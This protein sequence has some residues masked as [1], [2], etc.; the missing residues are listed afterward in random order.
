MS[1]SSSGRGGVPPGFRFHPTD[2]ELLHFYLKKKVSLQKFDMEVIREVDLNKIEPWELQERCKIGSTPQNEWYFFSHKD[3]K[4]PTGSRTNRATSAGF[5]KAT[6]RDKCIRNNFNK[7]GM[8]KT[9]VFYRGRAPHGQ[10]TDWIMHEYRLEDNPRNHDPDPQSMS[11]NE[12][13]WVVCRVF[14]KKKLLKDGVSTTGNTCTEAPINMSTSL[15]SCNLQSRSLFSN[16][17]LMM[18]DM[19]QYNVQQQQQEEVELGSEPNYSLAVPVSATSPLSQYPQIEFPY[20]ISSDNKQSMMSTNTQYKDHNCENVIH[21]SAA[22][23]S[24]GYQV[25]GIHP[26]LI[27]RCTQ[28]SRQAAALSKTDYNI[29]L[30]EWDP[31]IITTFNKHDQDHNGVSPRGHIFNGTSDPASSGIV[32]NNRSTPRSEMHFW[33]YGK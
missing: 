4:Y 16:S 15:T 31:L 30:N 13:G 33:A 18:I 14:M 19:N 29:N 3:R 21:A 27:E 1:S 26:S 7:I 23:N 17:D 2:E 10:K 25:H 20:S 28:S 5:W 24:I 8:R 11:T 32:Q 9:L 22:A 12:D 6:G